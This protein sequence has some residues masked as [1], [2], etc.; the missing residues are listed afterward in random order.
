VSEHRDGPMASLWGISLAVLLAIG[1][2]LGWSA[3]DDYEQTLTQE[4]VLLESQA[5]SGDAQISGAL[6]SIDLRTY[7]RSGS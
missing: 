1:G 5:R 2:Y 4:F 6:R 7:S 3:H